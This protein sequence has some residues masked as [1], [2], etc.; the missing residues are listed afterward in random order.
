MRWRYKRRIIGLC[1]VSA[2]FRTRINNGL[3]NLSDPR[4]AL[5]YEL[6]L[7]ILFILSFCHREFFQGG[8]NDNQI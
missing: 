2:K 1:L 5:V 4:R 3:C 6:F 7:G 8:S